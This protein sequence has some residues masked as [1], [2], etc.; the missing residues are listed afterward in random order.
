M[1]NR[2]VKM[3]EAGRDDALLRFSLG[4]I[5]LGEGDTAAAVDHLR[6]A[7]T[8]DPGYSAAWKLLGKALTQAGDDE[9]A[10]A[11]YTGGIEVATQKGDMQAA[12]EM[13]VFAHRITKKLAE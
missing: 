4:N 7:L 2:L 9:G 8:H 13:S 12:K 1:K 11:A 10:L 3:L 6:K 5:Y